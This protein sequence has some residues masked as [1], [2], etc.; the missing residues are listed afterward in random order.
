MMQHFID[1]QKTSSVF[2][3]ELAD[4]RALAWQLEQLTLGSVQK[5]ANSRHPKHPAEVQQEEG[6]E[7]R[8]LLLHVSNRPSHP[9]P[10]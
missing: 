5:F 7:C 1:V 9:E 3:T 2:A 10:Y 8:E 4:N 6:G